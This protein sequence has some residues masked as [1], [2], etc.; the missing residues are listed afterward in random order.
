MEKPHDIFGQAT[1]Y[2][3]QQ[4]DANVPWGAGTTGTPLAALGTYGYNFSI[5]PIIPYPPP[6]APDFTVV[7]PPNY[8]DYAME[9]I[10]RGA[11]DGGANYA[12]CRRASSSLSEFL[13]IPVSAASPM[14]IDLGK[15][16][17]NL[18]W[19]LA[20]VTANVESA[21][22]WFRSA[23]YYEVKFGPS[24]A[25]SY[26]RIYAMYYLLAGQNWDAD[27]MRNYRSCF[28]DNPRSLSNIVYTLLPGG[29][30]NKEKRILLSGQPS[31][32]YC[33]DPRAAIDE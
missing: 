2:F 17:S 12:A 27:A 25:V 1:I 7:G 9:L 20:N 26:C 30:V 4:W 18:T 19:E 6:P 22:Q 28:S 11:P 16:T 10:S 13:L 3:E 21:Y 33:V 32:G 15:A 24:D 5:Q 29:P 14:D 31:L 8:E 23:D